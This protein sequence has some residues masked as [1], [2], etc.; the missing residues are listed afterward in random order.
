MNKLPIIIRREYLSRVTK[1]SFIL[2]TLLVPVALALLPA[3]I[4]FISGNK[5]SDRIA[6]VDDSGLFKGKL[7][8]SRNVVFVFESRP[9]D[10]LKVSYNNKTANYSG[11]LHIPKINPENPNGIQYFSSKS[12]GFN[13]SFY[14]Q[15]EI[16]RELEKTRL[17]QRGLDQGFID[18][19]KTK[20]SIETIILT[21]EG[22]RSDNKVVAL[23]TAFIMGIIIYITLIIYGVMVMNGVVEEK[24]NRILEVI[25]SS[26]RPFEMLMGKILGIAAV[27]LTQLAG[28]IIISVVLA[29][30]GLALFGGSL[31]SADG[32]SLSQH[33]I[34]GEDAEAM[35]VFMKNFNSINFTELFL[36]FIFYFLGGYL[37]YAALY[38]AAASGANDPGDTQ[39]LSFPITI[40]IIVSFLVMQ[41]AVNDPQGAVAFWFSMIPFTSPIVMLARIPFGVPWWQLTASVVFLILGFI[42]TT[43]IAAKIYRV[44]ILMYG[45]K[46]T[47]KELVK[48]IFYKG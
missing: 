7:N 10:S 31:G 22:E 6:V 20:A 40:P 19:L 8:D 39:A 3:L 30:V 48:W 23:I 44:G 4:F 28:W 38:A 15:S 5:G 34:K 11:L 16:G 47:H 18:S 41:A 32:A 43:W 37:F 25:V 45:K 46:V 2:T 24:A 13:S 35:A 26:V 14:I 21:E 42:G 29:N 1:R 33:G 36:F 12:L 27:G 17:T 9:L